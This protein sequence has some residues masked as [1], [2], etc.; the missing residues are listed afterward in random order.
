MTSEEQYAYDLGRHA[1]QKG[2][3][4]ANNPWANGPLAHAWERG[5]CDEE[6]TL[7]TGKF[8]WWGQ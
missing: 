2:E 3:P 5:Y 1:R 7:R 6:T 8:V 4:L